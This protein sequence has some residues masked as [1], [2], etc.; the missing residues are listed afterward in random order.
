M[1]SLS[2]RMVYRAIDA[3]IE[4]ADRNR[5]GTGRQE[6]DQCFSD[7]RSILREVDEGCHKVVSNA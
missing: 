2:E 5:T 7:L 3:L 1:K 4:V 6:I